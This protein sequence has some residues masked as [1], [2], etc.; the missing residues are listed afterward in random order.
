MIVERL[1]MQVELGDV[2]AQVVVLDGGLLVGHTK[3]GTIVGRF[4]ATSECQ[5][6]SLHKS[7]TEWRLGKIGIGTFVDDA[8]PQIGGGLTELTSIEH[9]EILVGVLKTHAA[10]VGN[11]ELLG[12]TFSRHH[13]NNTRST[14]ATILRCLGCIFQNGK[15]LDISGID[16]A[17]CDDVGLHAIDYH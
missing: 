1:L 15:T 6:M 12:L 17:K 11:V 8:H 16:G 2:V 13:L 5:V 10:I 4:R 9:V 7:R 14:T 3:R